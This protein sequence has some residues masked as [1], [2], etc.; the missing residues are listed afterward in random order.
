M[1][2]RGHNIGPHADTTGS[3]TTPAT[4]TSHRYEDGLSW[5]QL[6]YMYVGLIP[7]NN[8][9]QEAWLEVCGEVVRSVGMTWVETY[10]K[11]INI[12]TTIKSNSEV[13]Y[14][15]PKFTDGCLFNESVK[16]LRI[17]YLNERTDINMTFHHSYKDNSRYPTIWKGSILVENTHDQYLNSKTGKH[18]ACHCLQQLLLSYSPTPPTDWKLD[19]IKFFY[20]KAKGEPRLVARKINTVTY[21][22]ICSPMYVLHGNTYF[23]ISLM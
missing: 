8:R 19:G 11:A 21:K 17:T 16:M 6:L 2:G 4:T 1:F 15:N 20:F 23:Y 13:Y 7:T 12:S 3:T 18:C 5:K 14:Y 9:I 22:S 10:V